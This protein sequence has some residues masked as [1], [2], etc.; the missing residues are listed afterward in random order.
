MI[1]RTHLT[2]IFGDL[3][4][5][6][7]LNKRDQIARYSSVR[8]GD[9][10]YIAS[11]KTRFDAQIL[12]S[13]GAGVPDIDEETMAMDF[14]HKLDTKRYEKMLVHMRRNALC[15]SPDAY[16]P[17]LAAALRIASGWVD[18]GSSSVKSGGHGVTRTPVWAV[19]VQAYVRFGSRTIR[20]T[21]FIA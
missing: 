16:P 21:R 11:F 20:S 12:A 7:R 8:Q 2:H 4:P 18:E 19:R 13:R 6:V 15:N 1:H 10:D 9:R 14:I 5:M 3:D 17:T